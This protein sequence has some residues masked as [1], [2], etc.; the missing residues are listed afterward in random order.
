[1]IKFDKVKIISSLRNI[2]KIR[3]EEFQSIVK[4]GQLVEQKFSMHSPFLL[5]IEAD[6]QEQELI[7]EF[8]GKILNDDYPLLINQDTIHQCLTNINQIGLCRLDIAAIL[9]DGEIVKADVCQDVDCT[10]CKSLTNSLRASIS[11][12][13]K[14]LPR[15][16]NGNFVIEKN[17]QTK[18][19]KR[20]LTIYD[21]AEE[22]NRASNRAFLSLLREKQALLNYFDGKVRFEMNLNSKEQIRQTL[23]IATTS[24][25]AVL[26]S[27]ANPI[28]EFLDGVIEEHH[29]DTQHASLAE[30]KNRLL[31]EHCGGDLAKVEALLRSYCSP[32]THIS[33]AMKPYRALA[34]KL[35]DNLSP[36][37]KQTLRGL[38]LEIVLLLGFVSI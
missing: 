36:S 37:L 19:R 21:K 25:E 15:I 10:D 12:F 11:N 23:H 17:V 22:L 14:Y 27:T 35:S 5:Y 13:Q 1:M 6:Y 34:A 16:I 20:R 33:Q 7:I 29:A 8:T 32:N 24:L 18:S 4:N 26:G 31:L 2:T 38:L 28:W 9:A 3:E 30:L